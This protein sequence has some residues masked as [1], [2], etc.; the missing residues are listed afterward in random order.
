MIYPW[1]TEAWQKIREHWQQAAHAW[2]FVGQENT[3]KTAFA[4]HMAQALLCETPQADHQACNTC[5]SCHLFTQNS[6]P[7]FYELTPEIPEGE[8]L[9]RKLLQI[10]I[11]EVR[12]LIEP[13]QLTSV[14]GGK[15]VVLIHP[16]ESMN[17]QAAN[18]L[19]KVLEEPPENVVFLLVSHARD[20]LLPTIK[21]RCRQ[22]AL[23]SPNKDEAL[24]FVAQQHPENAAELLA[25]H[26]NAPLFEHQPELDVLRENLLAILLQP[27]L[28]AILDYA[29]QFDQ[30]K[31]ALEHFLALIQKFLADLAL[32]Q[33]NLNILYYPKYA[34]EIA[35]VANKTDTM[36][37][38]QLQTALN[39]LA[40]YGRHTLNVRLQ[41][42]SVL[43]DY[44][45]FYQNK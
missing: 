8:S 44:L 22:F 1:H 41:I 13:L 14:R 18:A 39:A 12:Q 15:R 42:E 27:R 16:A 23:P 7:D 34:T 3:G 31:L 32:S 24:A 36:K 43:L 2:L 5:S 17:L 40:P 10:K 33:Q 4:R 20:K 38:F 26:S 35:Q 9:G 30:K 21:S 29:Q 37:L 11:D 45:N 6:H 25:F 28:L 19:L